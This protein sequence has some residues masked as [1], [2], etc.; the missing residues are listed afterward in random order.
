MSSAAYQDLGEL[1]SLQCSTPHDL[2]ALSLPQDQM[3]QSAGSA[4]SR[5]QNHRFQLSLVLR[6]HYDEGN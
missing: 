1:T 4:R 5:G 6:R 3:S 2:R